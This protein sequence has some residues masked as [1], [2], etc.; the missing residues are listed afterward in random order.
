L[1]KRS[2]TVNIT[3]ISGDHPTTF[4]GATFGTAIESS[5]QLAT[6][7][8]YFSILHLEGYCERRLICNLHFAMGSWGGERSL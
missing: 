1:G 2:L 5:E 3:K 6:I 8:L 7:E 4:D